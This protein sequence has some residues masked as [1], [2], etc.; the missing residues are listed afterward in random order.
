[1]PD[2]VLGDVHILHPDGPDSTRELAWY[3]LGEGPTVLFE[4]GVGRSHLTW[5]RVAPAVAAFGRAVSYDR[6]G[7]GRSAFTWRC[8][9]F[10]RLLA[11][12]ERV[13]DAQPDRRIV[14]VGHS[15]GG[16]LVRALAARHR[17]R[18]AG[19]VLV[20]EVVESIPDLRGLGYRL[21]TGTVFGARLVMGFTGPL[22]RALVRLAYRNLAGAAWDEAIDAEARVSSAVTA[23]SETWHLGR[24]LETLHLDPP[25]LPAVPVVSLSATKGGGRLADARGEL[26]AP[27]NGTHVTVDSASHY[28]HLDDPTPVVD[29]IRGILESAA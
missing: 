4:A 17:E 1:M 14:L 5:A 12:L 16:P 29:A 8:R 10:P 20:D 23:V 3:S 7:Y 15:Y 28:F 26:I 18:I 6:A 9:R 13:F 24:G 25:E 27:V 2:S 22:R 19:I 21:F 11:D